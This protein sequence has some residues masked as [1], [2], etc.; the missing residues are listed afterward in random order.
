MDI[1][2]VPFLSFAAARAAH[3]GLG[4]IAYRCGGWVVDEVDGKCE[5]EYY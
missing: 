5:K 1:V 3:W 4:A 2:D